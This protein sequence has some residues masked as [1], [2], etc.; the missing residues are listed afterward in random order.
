MPFKP[1]LRWSDVTPKATFLNR[2]QIIASAG[3]ALLASPALA[4]SPFST[5]AAPNTLEE[6]TNY[7]N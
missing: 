1:D 3:A 4:A 6:I 7:N 2:R 5:D